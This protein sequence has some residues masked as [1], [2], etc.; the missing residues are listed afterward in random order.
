MDAGWAANPE[1]AAAGRKGEIA[2]AAVLNRFASA[3]GPTVLHDLRMPRRGSSANIDHILVS[4]RDVYI[5]DSKFWR[6]AV[7]WSLGCTRRG[8]VR[9]TTPDGRDL[10]AGKT[11]DTARQ[12]VWKYLPH[13]VR[14]HRPVTVVWPS[15][16]GALSV[17]LYR[18]KSSVAI[19]GGQ[20]PLYGK[21]FFPRAPADQEVVGLLAEL[22]R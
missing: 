13:G 14:V 21:V 12:S 5:F 1:A 11:L 3:Y 9:F 16:R 4:G 6:P 15:S 19:T 20:L 8:L 7:Y 17:L 2:T 18:P 10:G 22:L